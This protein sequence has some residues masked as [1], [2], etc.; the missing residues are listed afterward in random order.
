M[1]DYLVELSPKFKLLKNPVAR[2][3]VGNI[4]TLS[5]AAAIGGI[6]VD[7]LLNSI[8]GKIRETTGK[9]ISISIRDTTVDCIEDHEA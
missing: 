1:L 2:K 9:T 8:A 5:Q 3:T 4:A 6:P 7:T